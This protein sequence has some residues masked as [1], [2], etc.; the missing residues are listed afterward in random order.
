M[1]IQ[2]QPHEKIVTKKCA[3]NTF[4]QISI[5]KPLR[6]KQLGRLEQHPG[7]SSVTTLRLRSHSRR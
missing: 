3:F 6:I 4:S 5:F 7:R 2:G 1:P